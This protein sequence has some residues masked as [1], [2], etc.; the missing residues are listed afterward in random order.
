MKLRCS[1]VYSIGSALNYAMRRDAERLDDFHECMSMRE[2]VK[3]ERK[4]ETLS[5][6][7]HEGQGAS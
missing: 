3:L 2:S 5:T 1:T 4:A 7:E 6:R